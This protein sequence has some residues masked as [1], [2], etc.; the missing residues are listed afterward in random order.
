M[1]LSW[2][3][4][5]NNKPV[6]VLKDQ[7]RTIAQAPE[8]SENKILRL[9]RAI[10]VPPRH[11]VVAEVTCRDILVGQHIVVP[12][13]S[14][15]FE[16]P[17]LKMESMCYDNPE[18]TKVKILPVIFKN[19]DLSEYVYLPARMVVVAA[20]T[21][22]ENEVAYAEIAEINMT[23]ETLEEQC[24]NWLPRRK[25]QTDFVVSP[26]DVNEHCKVDIPNGQYST[27]TKDK[28]H[29]ML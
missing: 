27:S 12:D 1:T 20:K 19:L 29:S 7:F 23:T 22:G 4:D 28:L 11:T 18:E 21:K 3:N 24:R 6:K 2:D 8:S 17:N 10:T 16:K 26:A 25:P 13:S 5:E 9:K 14:L 15:M